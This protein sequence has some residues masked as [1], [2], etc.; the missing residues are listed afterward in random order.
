MVFVA[1]DTTNNNRYEF[2][3][4]RGLMVSLA[5]SQRVIAGRGLVKPIKR[6][7]LLKQISALAASRGMPMP[8]GQMPAVTIADGCELSGLCAAICP[9]GALRRGEKNGTTAL[10]FDA[11]DCLACGE[12]QRVCPS[13][14][15]SLW[16]AG[17]GTVRD[18]PQTLI[19]RAAAICE[20]CGDTFTAGNDRQFCPTCRKTMNVMRE[21]AS[22][23]FGTSVSS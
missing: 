2:A 11:A 4:S 18:A 20:G 17:D 22:W 5:E 12:C 1:K 7:R 16:A 21:F 14:A 6:K 10:E 23:K 13:S 19:E 3:I 15:L 9:T 8:S